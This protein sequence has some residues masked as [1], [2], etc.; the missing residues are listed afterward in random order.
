MRKIIII[1]TAVLLLLPANVFAKDINGGILTTKEEIGEAIKNGFEGA[2]ED[3]LYCDVVIN[4]NEDMKA[5]LENNKFRGPEN[6]I[7]QIPGSSTLNNYLYVNF[8]G[9]SKYDNGYKT[10]LFV[11]FTNEKSNFSKALAL[12]K[13]IQEKT[14]KMTDIEK[15]EFLN[16]YLA[17]RF[18]YDYSYKS[19]DIFKALESN[20]AICAAYSET[21]QVLCE[22]AGLRAGIISSEQMNHEWNY[23]KI[24]DKTYYIDVTW[25]DIG[26]ATSKKYFSTTPIHQKAA[27][28]QKIA[29]PHSEPMNINS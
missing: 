12:E 22:A 2:P 11:R 3:S 26:K 19:S 21:F 5:F 4:V 1:L 10:S 9:A 23:V 13:E 20:K 6:K 15:L 28:D 25:N 29:S 24:G 7:F 17:Q 8:M 27:P 18:S 14:K 16:N